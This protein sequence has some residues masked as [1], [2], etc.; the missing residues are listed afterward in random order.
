MKKTPANVIISMI[1]LMLF[2]GMCTTRICVANEN[3]F[4]Y[5]INNGEE[6]KGILRGFGL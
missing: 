6:F 1:V 2:W 3:G 4:T 5:V